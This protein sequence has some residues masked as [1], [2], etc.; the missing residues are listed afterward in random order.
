MAVRW[1]ELSQAMIQ[2]CGDW[3]DCF[4]YRGY[5]S[6]MPKGGSKPGERRGGR[7]KGTPNKATVQKALI[8]ARTV[9]EAKMSGKKLAKEV[10]EDFMLLFAGMAGDFQTTPPGAAPNP[11]ADEDKFWKFAQ[12]AIDCAHKLA[13]Y[14]SPTFRAVVVAPSLDANQSERRIRFTVKIFDHDGRE[15]ENGNGRE[16]PDA[17]PDEETRRRALGNQSAFPLSKRRVDMDHKRDSTAAPKPRTG[18]SHSEPQL[19]KKSIKLHDAR[20]RGA[21]L[22]STP[23][24][25]Q[26]MSRSSVR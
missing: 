19:E 5:S 24:Q 20:E 15:I 3:L 16:I 12:A 22:R 9:A 26:S 25:P 21:S 1:P 4:G 8:A 7:R 2:L 6:Q 18:N 11:R 14:Q 17:G 10:L 23:W 13:P